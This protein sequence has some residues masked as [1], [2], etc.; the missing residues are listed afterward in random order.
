MELIRKEQM[1][2]FVNVIVEDTLLIY[3]EEGMDEVQ[4]GVVELLRKSPYRNY[5]CKPFEGEQDVVYF[6]LLDWTE[7]IE[8][9]YEP[10]PWGKYSMR[11]S[12]KEREHECSIKK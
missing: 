4:S 5:I 9:F 8:N 12:I 11:H 10:L 1:K 7:L 2:C 3:Y 6:M